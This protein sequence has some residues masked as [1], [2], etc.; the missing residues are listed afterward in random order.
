VNKVDKNYQ[1]VFK[2]IGNYATD[3]HFHHIH[4]PLNISK[5]MV[6]L[7][8][9]MENICAQCVPITTNG[10]IMDEHQAH[11]VAQLMRGLSNFIL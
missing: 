3:V 8:R 1:V 5:I 2:K 6:T 11:I 10:K 9:T 4:I 7:E